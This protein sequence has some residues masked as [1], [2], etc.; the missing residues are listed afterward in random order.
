MLMVASIGEAA[1]QVH[2]CTVLGRGSQLVY[3]H[4]NHHYILCENSK[5]E[6]QNWRYDML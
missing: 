1:K 3:Q 5:I 6:L 4:E 2:H